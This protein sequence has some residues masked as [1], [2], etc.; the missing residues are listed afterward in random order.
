M[1]FRSESFTKKAN[2][3][4]EM[5]L[6]LNEIKMPEIKMLRLRKNIS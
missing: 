1:Y 3:Y 6:Y 2:I 5:R 4:I